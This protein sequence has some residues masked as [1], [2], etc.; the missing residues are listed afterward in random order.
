MLTNHG[1]LEIDPAGAFPNTVNAG[2]LAND[3]TIDL[4]TDSVLHVNGD[5][6]NSGSIGL[7]L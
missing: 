1:R 5:A 4:T 2:S 7:G 3:G 6:N